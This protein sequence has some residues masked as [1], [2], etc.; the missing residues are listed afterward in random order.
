MSPTGGLFD[1]HGYA[2]LQCGYQ[3]PNRAGTG[4]QDYV[5]TFKVNRNGYVSQP[6]STDISA[7]AGSITVSYRK[8]SKRRLSIN[9]VSLTEGSWNNQIVFKMQRCNVQID[10]FTLLF[11]GGVYDNV[12][13]IIQVDNASDVWIN[14]FVTTGR[15]VTTRAF[16]I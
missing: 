3:V 4:T 1:G 11:T 7:F 10:N 16:L 15:P 8:T 6:L 13:A 12:M 5:Q 9:N 2:R 14:N